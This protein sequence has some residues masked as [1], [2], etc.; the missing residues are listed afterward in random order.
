MN[1]TMKILAI[2]AMSLGLSFGTVTAL[3]YGALA[4]AIQVSAE[5]VSDK[6]TAS[7]LT[8]AVNT[9]N[10]FSGV[11]GTSGAV[12]AGQSAKSSG[13]GIQL[14][15]KNSNSGIVTTSSGGLIRSVSIVV[16]SGTNTLD[17]Y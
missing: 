17:V 9:Y 2:G 5:T 16:E 7:M 15:S 4:S 8:G 1:K 11:T 14:R 12:Y 6:L 13:G 10:D 3:S